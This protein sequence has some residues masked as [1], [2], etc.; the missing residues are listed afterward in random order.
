MKTINNYLYSYFSKFSSKEIF[1]L[2]ISL[3]TFLSI[4]YIFYL[5]EFEILTSDLNVYRDWSYKLLSNLEPQHLPG[6]PV[7]I[8]FLRFIT[9]STV[10][11]LL[12]MQA[13]A[14]ACW[15]LSLFYVKG[16]LEE[17]VPEGKELGLLLFAL[18]PLFGI[19]FISYPLA[20]IVSHSFFAGALYYALKNKTVMLLLFC[21]LCCFFHKVIWVYLFFLIVYL[22][23]LRRVSLLQI[24][25]I[26]LPIT[27]YYLLLY[28]ISEDSSMKNIGILQNLKTNLIFSEDLFYPFKGMI[29]NFMAGTFP[30]TLK[31]IFILITSMAA[32]FCTLYSLQKRNYFLLI[33][34][35]P[36]LLLGIL[37]DE[38]SSSA[39]LRHAKFLI[40]P[41]CFYLYNNSIIK[42]NL[43]KGIVFYLLGFLLIYTQIQFSFYTIS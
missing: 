11:D 26:I 38:F 30:K 19:T 23:L 12:V 37:V 15:F 31:A 13:T 2:S 21:V 40:I 6:Y 9:F 29:D 8:A 7:I 10:S 24:G 20:D 16:I 36:T 17:I 4:N 25:L 1:V 14:L 28:F 41:I 27:S 5:S 18:Y 42:I 22:S 34:S 39:I 35:V 43:N 33:L 32:F 3:L